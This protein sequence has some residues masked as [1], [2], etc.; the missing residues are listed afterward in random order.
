MPEGSEGNQQSPDFLEEIISGEVKDYY[1]TLGV[2]TD[3]STEDIKKALCRAANT[4]VVS[5][6][7]LTDFNL[8]LKVRH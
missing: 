4:D 7:P 3:A 5:S 2:S 8:S 1:Q 6:S